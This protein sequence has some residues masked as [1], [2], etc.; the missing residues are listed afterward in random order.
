MRKD[1]V[2]SRK[3]KEYFKRTGKIPPAGEVQIDEDIY[4]PLSTPV[5]PE[6]KA[7]SDAEAHAATIKGLLADFRDLRENINESLDKIRQL[8]LVCET[9]LER[10]TAG[11][12]KEHRRIRRLALS[13]NVRDVYIFNIPTPSVNS[14]NIEYNGQLTLAIVDSQKVD[15]KI[16][17]TP[18]VKNGQILKYSP[19]SNIQFPL[20]FSIETTGEASGLDLE[21][22]FEPQTLSRLEIMAS[23]SIIEVARKK[24][25]D[26]LDVILRKRLDH[27]LNIQLESLYTDNLIVR[28]FQ[29]SANAGLTISVCNL[30][31]E[32]Y[33]TEGTYI[34]QPIPLDYAGLLRVRSDIF[35]PEESEAEL[36]IGIDE[37]IAGEFNV[38]PDTEISTDFQF[39][40][41]ASGTTLLSKIYS[42]PLINGVPSEKEPSWIL[43]NEDE[44]IYYNCTP[45]TVAQEDYITGNPINSEKILVNLGNDVLKDTIRVKGGIG[46]WMFVRK[47][48]LLHVTSSLI[49][50]LGLNS[51]DQWMT[52]LI[53]PEAGEVSISNDGKIRDIL[54]QPIKVNTYPDINSMFNATDVIFNGNLPAG[55]YQIILF[56]DS[57]SSSQ[58]PS[59]SAV[60]V[61]GV[62]PDN[63]ISIPGDAYVSLYPWPLVLHTQSSFNNIDPIYRYQ[64]YRLDEGKIIVPELKRTTDYDIYHPDI[65]DISNLYTNAAALDTFFDISY[66]EM[67]PEEERSRYLFLKAKLRSHDRRYSP[68][69]RSLEAELLSDLNE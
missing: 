52:Y 12:Y 23:P 27:Y 48:A 45:K 13:Q 18:F 54:V 66:V 7:I 63:Y 33:T 6:P 16:T 43:V 31:S 28:V 62:Q 35:L 49:Q 25:D 34:S 36:Y 42:Y 50:S 14:Y 5:V 60:A 55:I 44:V 2:L 57:I 53:M 39:D 37:N 41:N 4:K 58:F 65:A 29:N 24:E 40:P 38:D 19:I 47:S 51:Y 8:Y 26:S 21:F 3:V 10:I 67:V 11:I 1:Q 69:I 32:V 46:G 15:A 17:T 61:T 30:Y 22:E 56:V 68:V 20:K 9:E 59:S 64:Y